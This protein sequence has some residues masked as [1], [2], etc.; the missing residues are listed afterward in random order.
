L[1]SNSNLYTDKYCK[2]AHIE[3]LS[4][5]IGSA[6]VSNV[7]IV[8]TRYL[9]LRW[10]FF[11]MKHIWNN[12]FRLSFNLEWGIS[13]SSVLIRFLCK[14][15]HKDSCAW[16]CLTWQNS[17]KIDIW[18]FFRSTKS[19]IYITTAVVEADSIDYTRPIWLADNAM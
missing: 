6:S 7:N 2:S 4:T 11:F 8:K 5:N 18:S 17:G 9:F 12:S 13:L 15:S 10:A 19:T 14:T 3:S 16:P 1:Q